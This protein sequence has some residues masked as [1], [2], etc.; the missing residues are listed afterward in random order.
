MAM[1]Q[2]PQ[3]DI[4]F[5]R[6]ARDCGIARA[7]ASAEDHTPSWSARARVILEEFLQVRSGVFLAEDLRK[8]AYEQCGLPVPPSDRAWGGVMTRAYKEG[9]IEKRGY[10]QVSNVKAHRANVSVWSKKEQSSSEIR[11]ARTETVTSQ[12]ATVS[13]H[14]KKSSQRTW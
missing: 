5:A 4:D 13:T 12:P 8:F 7:E 10:S 14:P 1:A 11:G 9:I 6:K 3:L 2:Y